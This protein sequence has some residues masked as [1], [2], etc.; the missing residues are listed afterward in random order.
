MVEQ[1]L[2]EMR[3][4]L[5]NAQKQLYNAQIKS[6]KMLQKWL[7]MTYKKETKHFQQRKQMALNQ[8]KEA[9]EAV[10]FFKIKF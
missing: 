4:H 6:P 5:I 7:M 8:M 2:S 9:K 10:S 3:L 1:E